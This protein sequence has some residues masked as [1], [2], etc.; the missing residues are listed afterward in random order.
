MP[1]LKAICLG[2]A[3]CKDADLAAAAELGIV[4]GQGWIVIAVNKAGLTYPGPFEHWATMHAEFLP[5]WTRERAQKGLPPAGRLW[6]AKRRVMPV[7]PFEVS[8]A[9]NWSGSSGLLAATVA[10]QLGAEKVVFCGVPL[11]RHQGHFDSPAKKW[12]DAAHYRRAWNEHQHKELVN[13]RS[14][15]GWTKELLGSPDAIW[16][17]EPPIQVHIIPSA[18]PRNPRN[19]RQP[20][21]G[22]PRRTVGPRFR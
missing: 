10:F 11:D 13:A 17:A 4:H 21:H 1:G 12:A 16:L 3:A 9:E 18:E 22:R 15:S 19:V 14:M 2:S 6:A 5:K 7:V 20:L 8:R